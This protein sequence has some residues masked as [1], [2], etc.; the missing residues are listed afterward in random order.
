MA[1]AK[2]SGT[3]KCPHCRQ[4]VPEGSRFCLFCGAAVRHPAGGAYTH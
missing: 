3:V 4:P 2:A 1:K